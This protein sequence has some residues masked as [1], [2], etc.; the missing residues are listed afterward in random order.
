M[1]DCWYSGGWYVGS[2]E[3]GVE[4]KVA[5]VE[6]SEA[7]QQNRAYLPIGR[8]QP[9]HLTLNLDTNR[10]YAN[11]VLVELGPT[12]FRML[13]FFMGHREQVYSRMQLLE[14]VWKKKVWVEERTVDVHV[15]RLRA[16]LKPF[17]MGG[18]IQTVRGRG[19]RFSRQH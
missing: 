18:L 14:Q 10:V 11:G 9:L 12:E 16:A 19:Y 7:L 3:R 5:D 13:H 8:V 17:G 4:R 6:L 15:Q 2:P 1:S